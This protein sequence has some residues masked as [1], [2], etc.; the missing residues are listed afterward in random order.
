M[1]GSTLS[2][3]ANRPSVAEAAVTA[4]AATGGPELTSLGDVSVD[5]PSSASGHHHTD[6]PTPAQLVQLS[7]SS[8]TSQSFVAEA[9]GSDGKGCSSKIDGNPMFAESAAEAGAIS[10][11]HTPVDP[12]AT[13][14]ATACNAPTSVANNSVG[15]ESSL[16]LKPFSGMAGNNTTKPANA[17]MA[18][19]QSLQDSGS[20]SISPLEM[21]IAALDPQKQQQQQQQQQASVVAFPNADY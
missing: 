20:A 11:D 14:T 3:S 2:C 4:S 13:A 8:Q 17:S 21:L 10:P 15:I 16:L 9:F 12:S 7:S 5:T 1:S 19:P 6:P 18:T